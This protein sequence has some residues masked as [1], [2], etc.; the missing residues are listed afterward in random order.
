M[1][2]K[3]LIGLP[4]PFPVPVEFVESHLPLYVPWSL[5]LHTNFWW[6]NEKNCPTKRKTN[7]VVTIGLG[8]Y[9]LAS[10]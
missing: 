2:R 8:R 4:L 7:W 1:V 6:G 10:P 3:S 9:V 5:P